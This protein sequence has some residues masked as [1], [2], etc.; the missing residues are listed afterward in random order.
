M[1]VSAVSDSDATTRAELSAAIK[2]EARRLG[3]DLAG[4]AP[5]VS[6]GGLNHFQNWL[7]RGFAGEMNY[8]KRR[9][10]AYEHPDKIL[11]RVRSVVMLA[12]N[13]RT[14]DPKPA[15]PNHGLVSRY[16]WGTEDYHD[17]LREKLRRLADFVHARRP[18]SQTRGVVDTA[19][20]L[21]R[22]FTRLAGLGW[23]GKNTMLIN[24]RLGSWLFLAAL[25]VDVELEAD[26]PHETSH[27]GTCTRCL[28][29]CPTDAFPEPYVLD[30]RRCISYLNIELR[31]KPI[32]AELREGMGQW[33]FGCDICQEVC[34]W[35]RKAPI[36]SEPAFQPRPEF[37]PIDALELL[38]LSQDEF[39]SRFRET[40]LDRPNRA[41]LLRNAA[42]VLGNSGNQRAIP[43]LV[44]AL[45]DAEPIVRGAAA[46]ALGRLGGEQAT[47]ALQ[48]R[49][50]VEDNDDVLKEL[51][52]AVDEERMD[53]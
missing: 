8:L 18:D 15:D 49:Q 37:S 41:G 17:V 40:P 23:F 27:C 32:P 14:A 36:S 25:L 1:T 6:P 28:D 44:E 39:Q 20:L 22:D 50:S 52:A 11:K 19:P 31:D 5:A 48:L 47:A 10:A 13:Y 33:L 45:N 43:A 42:I 16:A 9:E 46:W 2:A 38:G 21:E 34:P 35:N 53:D 26:A 29:A 51:R 3:F 24:K 12:V 4:I 7:Q 30:A